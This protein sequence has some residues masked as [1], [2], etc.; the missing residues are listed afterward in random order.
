MQDSAYNYENTN[1]NWLIS[2]DLLV[3][4]GG[5]LPIKASKFV[6]I[7]IFARFPSIIT[8][9]LAGANIM[10]GNWKMMIIVYIVPIIIVGII[11]LILSHF[12]KEGETKTALKT[13]K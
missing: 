6:A 10:K 12:D 7:S 3:Y 13:I 1:Y 5:L 4:I 8:S 9:T 2:K 11:I